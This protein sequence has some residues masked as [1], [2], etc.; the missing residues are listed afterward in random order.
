[1]FITIVGKE[2]YLTTTSVV[3][4]LK[5]FSSSAF[6]KVRPAGQIRPSK[7]SNPARELS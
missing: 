3:V 2:L 4:V 1:L 6:R 5:A 7:G